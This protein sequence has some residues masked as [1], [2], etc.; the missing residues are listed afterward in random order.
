MNRFIVAPAIGAIAFVVFA[1]VVGFASGT[2]PDM[3]V[4]AIL[5]A[6]VGLMSCFG[7]PD[8]EWNRPW[9]W[10]RKWWPRR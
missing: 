8:P 2:S 4:I 3:F 7:T 1:E 10:S 5:G 6:V 9:W